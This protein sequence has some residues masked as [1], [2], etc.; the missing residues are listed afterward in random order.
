[1]T[2]SPWILIIICLAMVTSI[3]SGCDFTVDY[4]SGTKGTFS[5]PNFPAPYPELANC[6]Y[7][8]QA[9]DNGRVQISFSFFEL[10]ETNPDTG[11]VYDHINVYSLDN[12]DEKMLLGQFCG[13]S[14]P[15]PVVSLHPKLE[16]QFISDYTKSMKGFLGNYEFL[17]DTWLPFKSTERGC[18]PSQLDGVS[19]A[20]TSP[21]LN[22]HHKGP[23]ECVY[24]LKRDKDTHLLLHFVDAD[25]GYKSGG[26]CVGSRVELYNGFPTPVSLPDD[27]V[28]GQLTSDR[29]FLSKSSR[30]VIRFVS[31]DEG[32]QRNSFKLIWTQVTLAEDGHCQG[33]LCGQRDYCADADR[34]V[35]NP[36]LRFCIHDDLRCNS[37]PNCGPSDHS[38]ENMCGRDIAIICISV[39]APLFVL[40]LIASLTFYYYKKRKVKQSVTLQGVLPPPPPI[41][42]DIERLQHSPSAQRHC[43]KILHTSFIDGEASR[44]YPSETTLERQREVTREHRRG[45]TWDLPNSSETTCGS[46]YPSPSSLKRSDGRTKT[47]EFVPLQ[48]MKRPSYHLMKQTYT[49]DGGRSVIIAE[50]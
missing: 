29:E 24:L 14:P 28:C 43:S 44:D 40:T 41:P 25:L 16:V 47:V 31:D 23:V 26:K 48:A 13:S 18:G 32:H 2:A 45:V 33:H 1:M 50:I 12:R 42:H 4:R 17:G 7:V 21:V 35:C 38:D 34:G 5:S 8:F 39:L 37:I 22:A 30:L 27:Q 20:I 15:D 3:E 6:H 46:E 11:C 36:H 10:E 9:A 19:G 49:D